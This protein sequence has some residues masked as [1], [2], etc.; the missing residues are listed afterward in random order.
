MD[1]VNL[2]SINQ[3]VNDHEKLC[4]EKYDKNAF[5]QN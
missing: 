3:K 1:K 4:L 5:S 2:S